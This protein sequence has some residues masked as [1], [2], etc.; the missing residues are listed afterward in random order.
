M[1]DHVHMMIAI[2]PVAALSGVNRRPTLTP[3]K[4]MP[5]AWNCL[6]FPDFGEARA[7]PIVI[8]FKLHET[9]EINMLLFTYRGINAGRRFTP[10]EGW[11]LS[12][13]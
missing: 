1:P 5:I 11:P 12:T 13:A 9:T 4:T 3:Q 7:T 8:P 10:G 2:P 6:S